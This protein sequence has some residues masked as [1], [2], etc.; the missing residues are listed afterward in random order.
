MV[1]LFISGAVRAA[2]INGSKIM[3]IV[4]AAIA[5]T[6]IILRLLRNIISVQY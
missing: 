3:A 2:R 1:M 5:T 4:I 6:R